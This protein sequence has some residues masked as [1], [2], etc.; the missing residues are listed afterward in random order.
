MNITRREMIQIG[1]GAS[2]GLMLGCTDAEQVNQ[3]LITKE[4]PSTG[5][6]I[7]VIGLGGR[8]YRL[9]EGWAENTD[10]Y[11]ATLGTFYELGGRVIDTSPNYG[12]SEIIMGNL[13]Q[14]LGIRNELFLATKVDRQEKEEGIERMRGSLERMHTDHF[15]LMQVHNLRGWEI[16]IPTLREWKEDGKTRYIGITTSSDRQYEQME[17]IMLKENLDFIQIDYAVDNRTAEEKLLP[18]ARDLGVGVLINLPFGRGRLFARVGERELPEWSAEFGCESW[19]QFFLKYVVSHPAVTAVIPG[20]TSE[21]NA[22]DNIGAGKGLLPTS[23]IRSRME[24]FIDALPPVERP[25]R[26]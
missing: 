21:R 2:A 5:E 12:D 15:E 26:S 24:E 1:A 6:S 16:Q 13:L 10:G 11:R 20:T 17:Q 18:L 19:G 14:D 23:Q 8:N 7:P 3:G 4:I 25:T 9:G 22:V